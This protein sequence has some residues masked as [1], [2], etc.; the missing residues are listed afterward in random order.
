MLRS[1]CAVRS[2]CSVRLAA[3]VC[4]AELLLI[5]GALVS[6]AAPTWRDPVAC[7]MLPKCLG[8]APSLESW[9]ACML[10]AL[11]YGLAMIKYDLDRWYSQGQDTSKG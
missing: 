1:T 5:I 11:H 10:Q 9:R 7:T 4:T 2:T 6:G 8:R 3:T